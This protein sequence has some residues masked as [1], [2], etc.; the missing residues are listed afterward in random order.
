MNQLVEFL[1]RVWAFVRKELAEIIRQPRLL[2]ILVLGPFLILLIFG[3]GYRNWEPSPRTLIVIPEDSKIRPQIEDLLGRLLG[4]EVAGVVSSEEEADRRLV[5][6]EVD[7]VV[8]TP[9]DPFRDISISQH[10]VLEVRHLEI[11]P[12]E[13]LH[14]STLERIYVDEINRQTLAQAVE[15]SQAEA[16]KVQAKVADALT[17]AVA[18]RT[19]LERGQGQA[20]LQDLAA[21][22]TDAQLLSFTLGSSVASFE[23]VQNLSGETETAKTDEML[24]R[25]AE[26]ERTI[27]S[28]SL[29]DPEQGNFEAEAAQAAKI[30]DDLDLINR[31][32]IRAKD[33]D[34]GVLTR[35]FEGEVINLS[36]VTLSQIDFYVPAVIALLLQHMAVTLAALS[37]VREK[38][39]GSI[40]LFRA[41]P[42][43]SGEIL[44]GKFTSYFLLV[45]ILG[46]VLTGLVIL[47]LN[48]P[49]QGTWFSY[50]IAIMTLLYASFAVGFAISVISETDSQAIQ[51]SMIILLASIF[52]TGF[53]I[54][55]HRLIPPVHI[56]SWLLPATYGTRML[57]DVMLRGLGIEPI[58]LLGL[59]GLGLVLFT[60]SW[61]RLRRALASV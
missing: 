4:I 58:L 35:P 10:P 39:G 13:Q 8:T 15:R 42:I 56:I 40:E 46:I 32:L 54:A 19:D 52:F 48:V 43:S 18:L 12:L 55:L 49:M 5:Q 61:W 51:Y 6:R 26:I 21:L 9:S 24:A 25:M 7:L 60:F 22:A 29:M 1:I 3:L 59:I 50:A 57:Q 16:E 36:P 38:Q 30:V 27:D 45:A 14:V 20:A 34:S 23:G 41:A 28:L 31:F 37:I 53:F 2:M 47:G 44:L 17:D 33:L 11:D